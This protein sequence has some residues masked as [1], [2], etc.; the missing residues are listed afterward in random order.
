MYTFLRTLSVFLFFV[1]LTGSSVMA[2]TP[3]MIIKP[4]TGGGSSV[5]DPNGDGYV[6]AKTGGVQL[7]FTTPPN[8]DIIQSEIPYR[9]MVKPDPV[10]DLLRGP[11]GAFSE[12]VGVDAAGSNAMLNYSD[13]T[14]ILYRYRIDGY[15][16]NSKS[17]SILMD[18][19]GKFGFTGT[20]A[21][22]N[23][24]VGN[25]GFEAEIVLLTNFRVEAFN[26]DGVSS[27]ILVA[28]Y[29]WNTNCQQSIAVTNA[30]GDADYFFDFYLPLSAVSSLFIP[31]T[32][33]RYVALTTMN[34]HPAMGNNAVS[35][36]AGVTT[37]SADASFATII[38]AQT[39][40]VPG[41]AVLDRS[42]CPV[43]NAVSPSNTTI[44]GTSTE[45]SGTT[46]RVYVYQS[47]GVT[48]VGSGT[49][50]TSGSSWT[51]NVS[52]LSPSVTLANGQIVKATATATGEGASYDNCSTKTV[53]GCA[54]STSTSGVTLTQISG[55]KGYTVA[56]SFP[57][58]TI[59]TWYNSDYTLAMYPDRSGSAVNI[60][61]PATTSGASQTISFATQQGQTFPQG[62]YYF[63]FQE[64]GKCVSPYLQ[65]CQYST[66]GTSVTPT[67]TTSPITTATTSITGTCGSSSGTIVNL[68]ING[69]LQRST[70]V[71]SGTSWTFSGLN[72]TTNS[73]DTILVTSG[74]AG[75]C[76]SPSASVQ[77]SRLAT[78]PSIVS[79]GCATTL[80]ITSITGYSNED[81]GATVSLYTPNTSGT[82]LGTS[83]VSSGIWTVTGLSLSAGTIVV[84]K[85]T[86]GPCISAGS[87]SDPL[88]I[89][90]QTNLTPYTISITAPTEGQSSVSGTISGGTY[91]TVLKAYIDQTLLGQTTVTGAGTW[92][93]SGLLS[94][95]LYTSGKI[96]ITLTTGTNCES[97]LSTDS[98]IVRCLN[99]SSPTYTGGSISY[100]I[101]GSESV[102]IT[103][104]QALTVYQFVDS[105]G[106]AV[107]PSAIGNGGS[108]TLSSNALFTDV[109]P[110]YVKAYKLLNTTCAVTA[111]TP[112]YFEATKPT[113]TVTLT[114][115]ALTVLQ[116]GSVS[117]VN[118]PF[119]A[120]SSSP[121]ADSVSITY[122]IAAR[123][124][125]FTNVSSTALASAPGNIAL[126]VAANTAIGTYS[127][128]ITVTSTTPLA[129][130]RSYDF[131]ITVYSA[132]SVPVI[133]TQPSNATICSGTTTTL[134]VTAVNATSYQWQSATAGYSGPYSNVVGG[135]GA[136]TTSYTTP[137]LTTK[138]Y[139]RVI[140]TNAT[141]SITSNA[142]TVFVNPTPTAGAIT[143]TTT[144]CAGAT[145]SYS[146]A[147]LSDAT[148]YTWSY[149][150]TGA[151]LTPST[152]SVS[153]TYGQSAT[154]GTLSVTGNNACG[155]GAAS[156]VSI[157]V[158]P[159]P[160]ITN[161]T[162]NTCNTTA[163][164]VTP[165]NVTNGIVPS[166]TTYS[167]SAP[168]V[169]GGITGGASGSAASAITGTL[170]NPTTSIQTATYTVTPVKGSCTGSTF[171][172]IVS[173][174]PTITITPT[175]TNLLC[176]GITAGSINIAVSGGTPGYTF[177]WS[178]LSGYSATTQNISSLDTG[179]YNLT[180]TDS[181]SCTQTSSTTITQPT[182]III[183]PTV[184]N[185][186]CNGNST[187]AFS[188][189]VSGGTTSYSYLWSDGS[190]SQNRTNLAA[191][192]YKVVVTD[193]NS[194]KDSIT[195]SVTEPT[196]IS[197]SALGSTILCNGGTS[198]I[199]V[200][201]SGGTGSL[202]YSL[203]GGSF[204]AGNTFSSQSASATPY[205]ITVKDANNCTRTTSVTITQPAVL[206]LSTSVTN[207]TCPGTNDGAIN[208]TVAG[209][210]T[211]YG[212]AWTGGVTT[213]DRTA[214]TAGSYSVTV[215]DTNGCSA[216]VSTSITAINPNPVTPTSITK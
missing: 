214:L 185:V 176:R 184:T 193:A 1:L 124:A 155:A 72:L 39:P 145:Q 96:N 171:T 127:G 179:T 83:T 95:D 173:V 180:V 106:T 35:D 216:L 110:V 186:L 70:T 58:G 11:T 82:L 46:I 41:E 17:Y 47:D 79:T 156:T 132:A 30:S 87:A 154:S 165:V 49:T 14:N 102:T 9:E 57:S 189:S 190:S 28:S 209:G 211:P 172:V 201:A 67:I 64:P 136:T 105:N 121:S 159:A 91:N 18:T 129:C 48:L 130:S 198:T 29:S 208:L 149:S 194:C 80:P 69:V 78:K 12:I 152:S 141:G 168:V 13:G 210:S 7:G 147:A 89:T 92:T 3:G 37:G 134:S 19:D 76:P 166:S 26:V 169:T 8:D 160:F 23:A 34:P 20:N 116:S 38:S 162:Q 187:G 21:D 123:S 118:L 204:Q 109:K 170:T 158:N 157:T 51:I 178:K 81:D 44:T 99:P 103:G 138:T 196:T 50:T 75:K 33:I 150:G 212:Y 4:A 40:T 164:S 175:A 65:D 120:K 71:I 161:I 25:P 42:V 144:I 125:G 107:G 56:N 104:T 191:G 61:N 10:G 73:C 139:Y 115:T 137:S 93:V 215:T 117:S 94:T 197:A 112:I 97:A 59:I 202:T 15:A 60:V 206:S 199:T 45:A 192:S 32:P 86:A 140:V 55:N 63:T 5:L 24:V 148:S 77:V 62:V 113:P 74:D 195:Q 108:V 146:I 114:S 128:T 153:I 54:N 213:E 143:G 205:V 22:P 6:S 177:T 111:S 119:S 207:E 200:T 85:V 2:Q 126:S 84:A 182:S 183:T 66:A 53:S 203:N 98:A 16:P 122:A 90:A 174:N 167:W 151:T 101:G 88:T 188:I 100:C 36:V 68:L 181:R 43:I 135:S 133:S 163:F 131:T 27:G 142:A 52:S 31:S